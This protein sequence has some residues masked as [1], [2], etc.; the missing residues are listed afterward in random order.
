MLSKK[1]KQDDKQNTLMETKI[2]KII[3]LCHMRQ[4]NNDQIEELK[5]TDNDPTDE[6]SKKPLLNSTSGW[7]DTLIIQNIQKNQKTN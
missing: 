4:D 5:K 6:K 2:S 3:N 1:H 7:L